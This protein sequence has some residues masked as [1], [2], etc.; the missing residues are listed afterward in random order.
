SRIRSIPARRSVISCRSR[1][2]S[3]FWFHVLGQRIRLLVNEKQAVGLH[4]ILWDGN[5]AQGNRAP[6]G[7]YVYRLQAGD[8]TQS[9]KCF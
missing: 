9:K 8:F 7:A 5:D 1:V 4:R 3:S 6:S 2:Q